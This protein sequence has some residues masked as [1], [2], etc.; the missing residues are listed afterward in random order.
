MI[1]DTNALS[2]F[3]AEVPGIRSPIEAALGLYIPVI[4]LGEYRYG[5]RSSRSRRQIEEK[6]TDLLQDVEVLAVDRTTSIFYA[7]VRSELKLAGTPIPEN[8]VWIAALVRQH[9]LPLLSRDAHFD[10]VKR[11]ERVSW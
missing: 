1:L 4:V 3:L 6:L 9:Q 5:V 11:I 2:D 10:V 8:D 7:E